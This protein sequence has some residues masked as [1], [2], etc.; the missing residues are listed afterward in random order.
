MIME[1]TFIWR[2][3]VLISSFKS[4]SHV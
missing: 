4:C 3:Y 1:S 2:R